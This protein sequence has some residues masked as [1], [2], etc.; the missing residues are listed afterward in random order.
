MRPEGTRGRQSIDASHPDGGHVPARG[1]G[2]V[3]IGLLARLLERFTRRRAGPT[4]DPE[5]IAPEP[6]APISVPPARTQPPPPPP[7]APVARETDKT[8]RI[9]SS[10]KVT[11]ILED[12]TSVLPPSD[13]ETEERFQ[14]LT[15][16][17]I[18]GVGSSSE[19]ASNEG[20][21]G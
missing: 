4:H 9:G 17:L 7:I 11:L 12:G 16:N 10:A 13:T 5:P 18:P 3:A 1:R 19:G 6:V 15:D 2:G 8:P 20:N 21:Q 14:Y